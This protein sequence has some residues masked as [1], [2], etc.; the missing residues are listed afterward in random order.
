M[1][2][3]W[4]HGSPAAFAQVSLQAAHEAGGA[5]KPS[6]K[7]AQVT[8]LRYSRF[9]EFPELSWRNVLSDVRVSRNGE[10][11]AKASHGIVTC[12]PSDSVSIELE[13]VG[14]EGNLF[15]L[16]TPNGFLE[17]RTI[18]IAESFPRVTARNA[19]GHFVSGI[20]SPTGGGG[21]LR[22]H[23]PTLS[24][25]VFELTFSTQDCP[26]A[27]GDNPVLS[28]W[29]KNSSDLHCYQHTTEVRSRRG[30]EVASSWNP[31]W[32]TL[33]LDQVS[34][35]IEQMS[36]ELTEIQLK[37]KLSSSLAELLQI[38]KGVLRSLSLLWMRTLIPFKWGL[39]F[40][41]FQTLTISSSRNPRDGARWIY[42]DGEAERRW[43]SKAVPFFSGESKLSKR[44]WQAVELVM[45][46]DNHYR[47]IQISVAI[48]HLAR[49][50]WTQAMNR[51]NN[52]F[53]MKDS[54]PLLLGQM[55]QKFVAQELTE[56]QWYRNGSLHG[57]EN[58]LDAESRRKMEAWEHLDRLFF[59]LVAGT[60]G[61]DGSW[62]A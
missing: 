5:P 60:I 39:T 21:D 52:G 58:F 14:L 26:A 51:G 31:D 17:R 54:L 62:N 35:E 19:D 46:A 40:D 3:E 42:P 45:E 48:E 23:I 20:L 8:R 59:R 41:Q 10:Q 53:K 50:Y 34:I 43:I 57:N 11:M 30:V 56:W 16:V 7:Q 29:L 22:G 33:E 38:K 6:P 61:Y 4:T 18:H 1:L 2:P 32:V 13:L 25:R 15:R 55:G 28:I 27:L 24:W 12:E 36:K 9:N 47:P 49:A 37:P 44:V